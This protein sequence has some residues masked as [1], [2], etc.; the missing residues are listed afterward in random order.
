M[1]FVHIQ[2]SLKKL[3]TVFVI[4]CFFSFKPEMSRMD[5]GQDILKSIFAPH[6]I[7][8]KYSGKTLQHPQAQTNPARQEKIS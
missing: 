2:I 6:I 4:F 7:D 1:D 3:D 5:V 8:V